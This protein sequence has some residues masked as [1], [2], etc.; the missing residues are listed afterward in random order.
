MGIKFAKAVGAEVTLLTR[1]A[2]KS[3]EGRREGAAH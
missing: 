2:S 1:L 3:E